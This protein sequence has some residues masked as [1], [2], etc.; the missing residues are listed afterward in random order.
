M[1]W[2]FTSKKNNIPKPPAPLSRGEAA[3]RK[4]R[5][6]ELSF[7]TGKTL[8]E[9]ALFMDQWLIHEVNSAVDGAELTV[10]YIPHPIWDDEWLMSRNSFSSYEEAEYEVI[11][12]NGRLIYTGSSAG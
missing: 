2:P 11:H 5:I 8:Q 12:N 6:E 9:S 7:R 10:G 4:E 1:I 3:Y